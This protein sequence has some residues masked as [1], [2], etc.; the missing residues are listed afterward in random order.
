MK[1]GGQMWVKKKSN[2]KKAISSLIYSFDPSP[3]M[4]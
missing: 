1:S 3:F 4:A 2:K